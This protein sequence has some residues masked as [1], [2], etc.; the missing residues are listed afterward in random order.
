M[1]GNIARFC[2]KW[3]KNH[4]K[5]SRHVDFKFIEMLTYKKFLTVYRKANEVNTNAWCLNNYGM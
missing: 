1:R 3:Q 4:P 2:L 5:E